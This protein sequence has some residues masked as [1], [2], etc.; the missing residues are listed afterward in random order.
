[1]DTKQIDAPGIPHERTYRDE[2][3]AWRLIDAEFP[4]VAGGVSMKA[5]M[6]RSTGFGAGGWRAASS[7][8]A[9]PTQYSRSSPDPSSRASRQR[10]SP[11]W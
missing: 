2:V 11:W 1:M 9:K 7:A 8:T 4:A 3:V 5:S 6:R 10:V